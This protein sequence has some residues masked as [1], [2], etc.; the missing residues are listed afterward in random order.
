MNSDLETHVRE[1]FQAQNSLTNRGCLQNNFYQEIASSSL[2][3]HNL[4]YKRE[5]VQVLH[6]LTGIIKPGTLIAS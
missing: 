6:G 3:W 2:V 1:G 5:G 4:C